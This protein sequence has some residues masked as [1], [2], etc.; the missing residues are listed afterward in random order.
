MIDGYAGVIEF[1]FRKWEIHHWKPDGPANILRSDEITMSNPMTDT[2]PFSPGNTATGEQGQLAHPDMIA[3]SE[4]LVR[5]LYRVGNNAWSMVGNGLSNQSFIEGPEGLIVI[6]TGESNEEMAEALTEIRKETNAPIVACIYTHFHYV[7]GTQTLLAEYPDVQIWG[8]ARIEANLKRFGGE[9]GPRSARGLVHQFAT[10]LPSDGPDGLVNVGLGMFLRNP[11][12]APFTNGHIPAHH[13]FDE[14]VKTKIAGLDVEFA[15]A[16]SDA[17]DSITIWF[18]VQKIA[19][20]NLVWP[21]LFNV[22]AIR[23][24]EYRDP[25]ILLKGL[26]ELHCLGADYLIGAHGPPIAGRQEIAEVVQDYRDSIQFLWD[27]TVRCA[28]LGLTQN[29]IIAKIQLPSYYNKHYTTRQFYGVIEHHVRQIYTGLFGWFDE[30][31][32][33]LFPTPAP[34]RSNKLI[35]GFGGIEK[36]RLQIDNALSSNDFRWAMELA[37]WLVRS[38]VDTQG[39][40][41]AGEI[42]DR[43]R[44]AAALRGVAYSTTAANIRNWCITRALELDGKLNL[45]RFRGHR[46]HKREVL[47]RPAI[48]SLPLLRVLLV[49]EK[50]QDVDEEIVVRFSD[51]SSAGLSIR[52]FVAVPTSGESATV[53]LTIDPEYWAEVLGGK[54]NLSQALKDGVAKASDEDK[55]RRFFGCFDLPTL[56]S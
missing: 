36:V 15:P 37:S 14:P 51:G 11:D 33:N 24:E 32:A 50:S 29:E 34:E 13:T 48:D 49:P 4:R 23:G 40:A 53:S 39:R 26:D 54:L 8:H 56:N 19:V 7:S 31:E 10:A 30:D 18:P 44:M 12:H 21:V 43:A 2:A 17:N 1:G 25:R 35:A 3:H 41:D 47:S 27:Q 22:F 55:V 20:N 9:V 46:F 5:K 6:D 52:H 28:N 42:E 38:E 16:P 45:D